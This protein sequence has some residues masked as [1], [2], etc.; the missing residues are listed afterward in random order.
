MLKFRSPQGEEWLTEDDFAFLRK[1]ILENLVKKG[2][3]TQEEAEEWVKTW[4][5]PGAITG[6]LNY[7]RASKE[8]PRMAKETRA[9]AI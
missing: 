3:L 4:K 9:A 6:G 2:C 5:Q 7:Y 1:A 8:V